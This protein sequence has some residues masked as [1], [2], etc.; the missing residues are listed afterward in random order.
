LIY[1]V[2]KSLKLDPDEAYEILISNLK[3][4]LHMTKSFSV[5]LL[6]ENCAGQGSEL[7][8]KLDDIAKI[9]KAVEEP[10]RLKVCIDTCHAFAA[11]YDIS[12][13]RAVSKFMKEIDKTI[14]LNKVVCFHFNDSKNG[15]AKPV[16]R[17]ENLG[18]GKIGND[19]LI[20]VAKFAARKDIPL[21]LE[22]PLIKNS[23]KKD[24]QVLRGW[25]S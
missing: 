2:G 4:V 21:I 3:T 17:H 1:H 19:G 24:L 20:A 5:P 8:S 15:L 12:T 22:T 18:K 9:M 11:G 6:L 10:K 7:G 23:H 25:I 16:D 14:G 13:S